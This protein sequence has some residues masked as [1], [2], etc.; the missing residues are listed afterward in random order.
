MGEIDGAIEQLKTAL[1][2][3][4]K[5][6]EAHYDLGRLFIQRG[7]QVN[8]AINLRI[9]VQL[10]PDE[11]KAQQ[12]LATL[13]TVQDWIG[14]SNTALT[15]GNLNEAIH[16]CNVARALDPNNYDAALLEG[17]LLEKHGDTKGALQGFNDALKLN[18]ASA[19]AKAGVIRDGKIEGKR[20]EKIRSYKGALA[21]YKSVLVAA[22]TDSTAKAAVVRLTPLAKSS[23]NYNQRQE[24]AK[25][26]P[27]GS[28]QPAEDH[29][30]RRAR[31]G[32]GASRRLVLELQ[33]N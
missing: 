4:P 14:K 15:A 1:L 30:H 24:L 5:Y 11:P 12:L 26:H 17:K 29:P 19:D 22:P 18:S 16:D 31:A 13:G 10:A 27:I 9:A 25:E 33:T 20:L 8:A 21:A 28:T 23:K 3:D 32:V 6:A 7:D 2:F